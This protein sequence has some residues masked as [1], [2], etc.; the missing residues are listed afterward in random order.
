MLIKSYFGSTNQICGEKFIEHLKV[1]QSKL[2]PKGNQQL[3][4]TPLNTISIGKLIK[5]LIHLSHTL[6]ISHPKLTD[7][8]FT[9][10]SSYNRN[11]NNIKSMIN[12]V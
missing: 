3:I 5:E 1:K 7:N 10:T 9:F 12:L 6:K 8:E 4:F 2:I 11:Q